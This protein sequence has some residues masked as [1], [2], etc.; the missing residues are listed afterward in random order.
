[1]NEL[2][3]MG[4]C[5]SPRLRW[6][7]DNGIRSYYNPDR[8]QAWQAI[9]TWHGVEVSER[10]DTE[11]EALVAIALRLRIKLWNEL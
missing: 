1:M 7:R 6:M 8:T 10:G 5:L 3:D 4:E 2:F 11:D 9:T